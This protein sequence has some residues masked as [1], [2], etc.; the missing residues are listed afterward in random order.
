MSS[1]A[2]DSRR[3]STRTAV[4][5]RLL[6]LLIVAPCAIGAVYLGD[7]AS[8]SEI[9]DRGQPPPGIDDREI[10]PAADPAPPNVVRAR[11]LQA[12]ALRDLGRDR[13]AARAFERAAQREP[14][15]W[16]IQRD[17]ALALARSGDSRAASAALERALRLNPRLPI[18]RGFSF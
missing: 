11:L 17:L 6:A 7:S 2:R 14:R 1:P 18:P 10:A 4:R 8:E 13:D 12:Y 9:L 5:T 15:N 3:D 16:V